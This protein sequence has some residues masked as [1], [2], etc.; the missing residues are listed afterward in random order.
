MAGEEPR[1]RRPLDLG[2]HSGEGRGRLGGAHRS[3][4]LLPSTSS[5]AGDAP[6]ASIASTTA[7][8]P[9]LQSAQAPVGDL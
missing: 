1:G 2:L 7:A 3:V 8:C 6:P 5:T 9:Y 4:G